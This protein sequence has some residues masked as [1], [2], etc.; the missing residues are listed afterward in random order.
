MASTAAMASRG[1]CKKNIHRQPNS[2]ITGPPTATPMTGPPAP[3][4]DQKPNAFTRSGL[5]N[6]DSTRA[7]DAAADGGPHHAAEDPGGDEHAGVGCRADSRAATI[8]ALIPVMNNRR[9][10]NRGIDIDV[11]SGEVLAIIG[12]NGA[13]KS[14]LVKCL[15]GAEIP[16]IGEIRVDGKTIDFRKPQDARDVGIETVYQTLALS[17]ALDIASNMFLGRERRRDGVPGALASHV[18]QARNAPRGGG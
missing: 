13:G 8:S 11:F 18:G 9:W 4:S 2:W 14:V 10:P 3:T 16:D 17:P 7:M 5:W 6:T 1:V 15:T 12:D